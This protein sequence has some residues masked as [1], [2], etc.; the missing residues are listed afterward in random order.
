[1]AVPYK[2]QDAVLCSGKFQDAPN[3]PIFAQHARA[4]FGTPVMSVVSKSERRRVK[5]LALL[6][7]VAEMYFIQN[8]TQSAIARRI[9][10]TPSNVSRMITDCQRLG[11][12]KITIS[13]PTARDDALSDALMDRYGLADA[14]VVVVGEQTDGYVPRDVA[15]AGA[16]LLR[17]VL[18][19]GCCIGIT[20]GRTLL[21]ILKEFGEPIDNGGSVVQL[22]GSIGAS[23]EEHD[24]LSLVQ[25][26]SAAINARPIYLSAPF[27]VESE[28][29]AASLVK[30][31]SNALAQQLTRRCDV[32]VVGI[33]TLDPATGS[34]LSSGHVSSAEAAKIGSGKAIGEIC[35]HPIDA[36]GNVAEPA[37]S[38][39]LMSI[40]PKH[41][42]SAPARIAV[43]SNPGVLEPLKAALHKGYLTHLVVDTAIAI[44]LLEA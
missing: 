20:W 32:I 39:R 31:T 34:L 16:A 2:I 13:R 1:M 18:S 19:P 15:R 4:D 9:D 43:V 7:D 27:I 8:M 3:P 29:I 25:R 33:G 44:A 6:A 12:V 23:R 28:A 37:F 40:H 36:Q 35:G 30:N 17:E 10:T 21:A 11:I 24:S 26:L 5:R 22:A 14:C 41:L 42:K 38:E